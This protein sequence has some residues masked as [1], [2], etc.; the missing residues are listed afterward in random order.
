[1]TLSTDSLCD[2]A[3]KLTKTAKQ[4]WMM[5][6]PGNFFPQ[7]LGIFFSGCGCISDAIPFRK[8]N[9]TLGKAT[10]TIGKVME[11]LG[12]AMKNNR[13]SNEDQ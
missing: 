13:K 5:N 11:S 2:V 6:N 4:K 12:K 9:E 10:K 7:M 1:M 3:W 8:S